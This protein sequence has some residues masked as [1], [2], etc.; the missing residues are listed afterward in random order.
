MDQMKER[1]IVDSTFP[2]VSTWR[3]ATTFLRRLL[4]A[5]A[6]VSLSSCAS[7]GFVSSWKAPD[8]APLEVKGAKVGAVV[9]MRDEASRRVAEDALVR[10]INARGAQGIPSYTVMPDS[11]P[12]TEAEAR[13]AFEHA[14][15]QGIVVM[16]PV[17]VDKEVV[18]SPVTY[19]E[20]TYR[21]Y[22]G[23]YYRYGWDS[24]W[25]LP[26]ATDVDVHTN[27]IVTIETLV[28]SLRQNKLVWAGK[29]RTT[30]PK[31]VEALIKELSAAA[32]KELQRQGLLAS[33]I[34]FRASANGAS[35]SVRMATQPRNF[36]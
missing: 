35:R 15:V 33:W 34:D 3:T 13:A 1:V 14:G 23:G 25:A 29:S 2:A 5:C 20:P 31:D 24:P 18:S 9:M 26:V 11:R 28:Y 12:A 30:N 4:V 21:S 10:E 19:L 6:L 17:S 36:S 27:T 8:A 32:A 7:N 16:R 22:W